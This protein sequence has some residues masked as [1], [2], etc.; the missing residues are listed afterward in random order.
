MSK[1]NPKVIQMNKYA[2]SAKLNAAIIIF[3]IFFIYVVASIVRA[4]T[5]TPITTY[6]V[7]SSNINNN[8]SV[9]GIAVRNEMQVTSTKSGYLIYF[10]REGEKVRKSSPVCTV[11]ET[12]TIIN[13]IEN[14][15]EEGTGT[16]TL[17]KSDHA[18]IR[19]AID[20]FKN[21]YNDIN[22]SDVYNFKAN[23]ESKVLELSNQVMRQ[24][25]NAG[26]ATLRAS[27]ENINA[28]ESGIIAYYTDGYENYTVDS[29]TETA[30]N[31]NE[32]KK[33]SLKTGDILDAG[34]TVFKIVADENWSIVC[35]L[36]KEQ[37]ANLSSQ[38]YIS[39][40]VNKNPT[41]FGTAD[42]EVIQRD[43]IYLLVL[44]LN[45]YMIEYIDERFLNV[46]IIMDK[47]EGLKVPNSS[48]IDKEVYKLDDTF[49]FERE[50]SS[51]LFV[52]VI[53]TDEEGNQDTVERPVVVYKKEE[54]IYYVRSSDFDD[55]DMIRKANGS[56]SV[57]VL[58]LER[59]TLKGVY[60]ANEGVAD[61]CEVEVLKSQDEFT[62]IRD[63]G[64]LK[65]YDNIVLDC[66]NINEN[67][68]LY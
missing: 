51:D 22:F 18:A 29:I 27:L 43:N 62:I 26:G 50:D 5:K 1:K 58:S 56:D 23:I 17:R 10:V 12:K 44:N 19:S 38:T 35:E 28:P 48:L 63:N 42:F 6:K 61:F 16:A 65:E 46:E 32:Y 68:P 2:R 67:Q 36:N 40:N 47:Y 49:V 45:K 53:V 3:F 30:F 57:P 37:A 33:T 25:V 21:S 31:R 9:T 15:G 8:I 54:N 66:Q 7:S 24:E 14:T 41:D 39:F 64:Y 34:S 20:T 13:A 4:V 52:N 60:M 11:D 59:D 55:T